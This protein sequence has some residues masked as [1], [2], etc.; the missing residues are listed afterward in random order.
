MKYKDVKE[1]YRITIIEYTNEIEN[2]SNLK[3]LFHFAKVCFEE[4]KR[5]ET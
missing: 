2:E 5:K 3:T 4:E 1:Y